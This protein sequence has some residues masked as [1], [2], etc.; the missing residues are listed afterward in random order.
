MAG[1]QI[2]CSIALFMMFLIFCAKYKYIEITNYQKLNFFSSLFHYVFLGQIIIKVTKTKYNRALK[3]IFI[4]NLILFISAIILSL[5]QEN[6]DM[7]YYLFISHFGLIALSLFYF[8]SLFD[9]DVSIDIYKI[10]S[11]WV[12]TGITIGMSL[13]IPSHIP[14]NIIKLVDPKVFRITLFTGLLGFIIMHLFFIK[15]FLLC[16]KKN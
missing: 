10:P 13:N 16:L 2:Y 6:G 15:A 9:V 1:F 5:K 14:L 3:S 8:N 4:I 12:I 7:S 11:F